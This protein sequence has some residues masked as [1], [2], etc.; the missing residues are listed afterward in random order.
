MF[1]ISQIQEAHSK[2]KTGAD[3]PAYVREI[4]LLGVTG[5]ETY[6]KDGKTVYFGAGDYRIGSGPKYDALDV[7]EKSD[8]AALKRDLK[9]HQEGRTNFPQF[10]ADAARS[11][12]EKWVVS[13]AAMTCTYLDKNGQMMVTESIPA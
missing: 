7:H 11:G 4:I 2:V 3:Y 10:C 12:V 5:Y 8:I 9:A 1:T 13:M 6:V